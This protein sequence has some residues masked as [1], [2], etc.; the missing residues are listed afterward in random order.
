MAAGSV[1]EALRRFE[2]HE[3]RICPPRR[4]ALLERLPSWTISSSLADSVSHRPREPS[5]KR[6]PGTLVDRGGQMMKPRG[7]AVEARG[8]RATA[9]ARAAARF[10]P[11]HACWTERS[12]AS[13]EPPALAQRRHARAALSRA[14]PRARHALRQPPSP[15][16]AAPPRC[17]ERPPLAGFTS[18]VSPLLVV[19]DEPLLLLVPELPRLLLASGPPPLALPPLPRAPGA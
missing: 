2:V 13:S 5:P 14:A 15:A 3:C 4:P 18:E 6:L 17:P 11:L 12:A 9:R 16:R 1:G 8:Q 19:P 7:P 10:S